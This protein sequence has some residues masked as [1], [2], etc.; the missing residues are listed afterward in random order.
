M[1]ED[2]LIGRIN[3]GFPE[4]R[5]RESIDAVVKHFGKEW[6]LASKWH[7]IGALWARSDFLATCE[8]L[9]LG[10]SLLRF[11]P[12][13]VKWLAHTVER[14]RDSHPSSRIGPAFEL[15]FGATFISAQQ[16]VRPAQPNQEG[17][18]FDIAIKEGPFF[19]LSF[20]N[21]GTTTREQT[22]KKRSREIEA[23]ILDRARKRGIPWV[24]FLAE[25][26]HYPN[27]T[28]WSELR[29]GILCRIGLESSPSQKKGWQIWP[30]SSPVS[31][32]FLEPSHT[33]CN[34]VFKAP[35]HEN[36][37][38]T[39][40]DHIDEACS[41]LN[42]TCP[43]FED[44]VTPGIVFRISETAPFNDYI[45]WGREY[46]ARDDVHIKALWFY[47]NAVVQIS[48]STALHHHV[49]DSNLAL[50]GKM[51]TLSIIVGVISSAP[52]R[53]VLIVGD[54]QISLAG[55]HWYQRHDLFDIQAIGPT[56]TVHMSSRPGMTRHGV[57]ILPDGGTM[58]LSPRQES[59]DHIAL[60]T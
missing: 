8:L 22:F 6:I 21:F 20:K 5:L 24:G 30:V 34:L 55:Y 11:E 26:D 45:Q 12:V 41:A 50:P 52:A 7:P 13:D 54:Q 60:F 15:L 51:P 2:V 59:Y 35:H 58:I 33:S 17:Y 19:R 29:S 53:D 47:Q 44:N 49:G 14:M 1:S 10:D 28:D 23:A 57:M 9:W 36:E 40:L 46:L 18:D 38:K 3:P 43:F 39:F 37:R 27:E 42:R 32:N 16:I 56:G 31:H 25:L 4:D 48:N